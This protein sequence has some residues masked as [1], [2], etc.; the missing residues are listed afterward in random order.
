MLFRSG[1]VDFAKLGMGATALVTPVGSDKSFTGQVWQLSPVIDPQTRQGM[2]RIA[3]AYAPQL[4][5]G[6]FASATLQGGAVVAPKLPD[7]AILSDNR[8]SYV[9]IVDKDGKAR[10]RDIKTG[11]VTDSGIAIL[12]G[13]DGSERVVVRSGGFLSP[14]ETVNP[15]L[16]R[17]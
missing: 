9:Y 10:R 14:G 6:G 1:E 16:V 13:L 7:S 11:T 15:K 2:A 8:G 3:L 12:S 17:Q 4:R 5:P